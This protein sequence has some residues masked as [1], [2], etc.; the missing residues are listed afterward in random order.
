MIQDQVVGV[1]YRIREAQAVL[2][3]WLE[4]VKPCDGDPESHLIG[5]I[6]TL[7]DGVPDVLDAL[8]VVLAEA[9]K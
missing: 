5:S 4:S 8:D 6:L 9:G 1:A 2:S 7:L 3:L